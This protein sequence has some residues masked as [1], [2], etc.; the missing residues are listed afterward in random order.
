MERFKSIDDILHHQLKLKKIRREIDLGDIHSLEKPREVYLGVCSIIADYFKD[1]G[2]RFL[3]S[4]VSLVKEDESKE[5]KLT[6]RFQS[7]Y[8]NIAGVYVGLSVG[9]TIASGAL[10]KWQKKHGIPGQI[11][12]GV[13]FFGDLSMFSQSNAIQFL[14]NLADKNERQIAVIE[15]IDLIENKVMPFFDFFD[16]VENVSEIIIGGNFILGNPLTNIQYLLLNKTEDE[17]CTAIMNYLNSNE[18]IKK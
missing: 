9:F 1:Y 5:I 18:E 17:T 10:N 16:D 6:V 11:S 7:Y 14:W 12:S 8:N 2:F 13:I 15:I 3:K 4:A